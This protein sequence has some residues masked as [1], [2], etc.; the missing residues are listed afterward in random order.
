MIYNQICWPTFPTMDFINHSF[1]L[2]TLTHKITYLHDH[3][4]IKGA[5]DT[6]VQQTYSFQRGT[7]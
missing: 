2:W 6:F 7:G 5:W 3:K 4:N 1:V